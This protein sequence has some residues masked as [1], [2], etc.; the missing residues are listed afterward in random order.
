MVQYEMKC[1]GRT[2]KG[3][4]KMH[5]LEC[6]YCFEKKP[7]VQEVD[8]EDET[9]FVGT[10]S[11]DKSFEKRPWGNFKVI[12]DEKN[13]KIKKITVKPQGILSL[14]LHKHRNEWWKI[15][16]GEGEVQIGTD[17]NQVKRGCSMVIEKYQVHRITNIGENDLV[18]VEVQTG[19]CMEDDIIRIDDIYGRVT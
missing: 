2:C 15:I 6:P 3:L 18:F 12:L 8:K 17:I 14:Q 1:C 4:E 7:I 16:T 11:G 10:F 9:L 13:V 19:L 5:L